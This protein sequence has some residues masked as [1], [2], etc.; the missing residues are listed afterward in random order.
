[1]I[2]CSQSIAGENR[3]TTAEPRG[4][5]ALAGTFRR[6]APGLKSVIDGASPKAAIARIELPTRAEESGISSFLCL[7]SGLSPSAICVS[8]ALFG[9][10]LL[11]SL[12]VAS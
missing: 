12:F 7:C 1:M 6:Y 11:V 3:H 8:F 9:F 5:C 10:L 4:T 2:V